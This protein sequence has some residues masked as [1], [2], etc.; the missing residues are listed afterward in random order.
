MLRRHDGPGKAGGQNS[1]TLS[2]NTFIKVAAVELLFCAKWN[3][4]V[5]RLECLSSGGMVMILLPTWLIH[6]EGVCN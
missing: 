1:F 3:A 6:C 2:G 5:L 4:P